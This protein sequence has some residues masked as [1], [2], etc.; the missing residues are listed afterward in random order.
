MGLVNLKL[1][2]IPLNCKVL[3]WHFNF[4]NCVHK[5]INMTAALYAVDPYRKN[6][7]S[8]RKYKF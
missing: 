2:M 7:Y 6:A 1:R 5:E 8:D 3:K 4:V